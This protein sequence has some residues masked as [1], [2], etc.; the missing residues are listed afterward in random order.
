MEDQQVTLK[1]Y[2]NSLDEAEIRAIAGQIRP[3]RGGRHA[4]LE[5]RLT[6]FAEAFGHAHLD[7]A[8]STKN[9]AEWTVFLERASQAALWRLEA[10][11]ESSWWVRHTVNEI[12]LDKDG[13]ELS[14]YEST[15]G[16]N[17]DPESAWLAAEE[18][19]EL[20][21]RLVLAV[22]L[23][24]AVAVEAKRIPA[25]EALA[26]AH[27]LLV[28]ML[29]QADGEPLTWMECCRMTCFEPKKASKYWKIC[30]KRLLQLVRDNAGG[31][32]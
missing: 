2:F 22:P 11:E 32:G 3:W 27:T 8:A 30:E 13:N 17:Q 19:A 24:V 12:R 26:F 31:R 10:Q 6:A 9:R 14:T 16:A 23:A 1:Q 20:R 4:A 18:A 7:H 28:R 15:P 25:D 29:A 5:K 21:R